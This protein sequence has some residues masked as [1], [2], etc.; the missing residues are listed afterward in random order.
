MRTRC[1]PVRRAI[2][3]GVPEVRPW[4]RI[5]AV[6]RPCRGGPAPGALRQLCAG[7][8]ALL[9]RRRRRALQDD[10]QAAVKL[11]LESKAALARA[12]GEEPPE[13]GSK[14]K[15]K[16]EK[17]GGEGA[18][19]AGGEQKLSK[20]QLRILERQR[21]AV[22]ACRGCACLP[23]APC[24][25]R[26]PFLPHVAQEARAAEATAAQAG[27]A[28]NFGELPVLQST[29]ITDRVWTPSVT[30]AGARPTH[31]FL[32]RSRGCP[33][34]PRSLRELGDKAGEKV[35][36]RARV[37]TSRVV[38]RGA[39]LLLRSGIH[40]A[41]AVAFQGGGVSKAMIKF[42]G[43]VT[44]ESVVD[45]FA[46]VSRPDAPIES[47][48]LQVWERGHRRPPR[49]AAPPLRGCPDPSPPPLVAERGA[50][51]GAALHRQSGRR[52]DRVPGGGRFTQR[53][54][55]GW[56]RRR[57]SRCPDRGHGDEARQPLDRSADPG[58]PG[59]HAHQEHR[60]LPLSRVLQQVR[61]GA[62]RRL[63]RSMLTASAQAR[64]R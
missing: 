36:V 54:P 46:T 21:Q 33:P 6:G 35:W 61:A 8:A 37:H 58:Q 24:S 62:C 2:G 34:A 26:G 29:E 38:G 3:G 12:R 51:G 19:A 64:I 53:G 41:Q 40:T 9:P 13:T 63:P 25:R 32:M 50:P 1:D 43:A 18:G 22:R 15:K 48:S 14:K 56:R 10:V 55:G 20:K 23:D 42:L 5:R 47:A 16:K 49:E 59:H 17:K 27:E 60:L 39:F 31:P 52:P 11:L 4:G 28:S 44:R 45:V 7:L 30:R 57:D